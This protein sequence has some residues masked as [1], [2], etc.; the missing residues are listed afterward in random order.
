[1]LAFTRGS[2]GSI[3]VTS[4]KGAKGLT[5]GLP[6]W[7]PENLGSWTHQLPGKTISPLAILDIVSG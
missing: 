1:M 7:I 4:V 6:K 3:L 2:K 5:P